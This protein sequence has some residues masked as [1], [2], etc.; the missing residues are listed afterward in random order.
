MYFAKR[1]V[2]NMKTATTLVNVDEIRSSTVSFF[3]GSS[4]AGVYVSPNSTYGFPM[5]FYY[6][7][8]N[9]K[10]IPENISGSIIY[11]VSNQQGTISVQG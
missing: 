2:N 10:D 9:S 7:R 8:M 1:T 5:E 11:K 6:L 3:P 4:I